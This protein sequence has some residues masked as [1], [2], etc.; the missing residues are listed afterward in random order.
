MMASISFEHG[1]TRAFAPKRNE[2]DSASFPHSIRWRIPASPQSAAIA[3]DVIPR[4][5]STYFKNCSG[6]CPTARG[7]ADLVLIF[8]SARKKSVLDQASVCTPALLQSRF[9]D[10]RQ[11]RHLP[12]RRQLAGSDL[13]VISRIFI[14]A[15]EHSLR[16][17]FPENPRA[18]RAKQSLRMV[19][20]SVCNSSPHV[21]HNNTRTNGCV[22]ILFSKW[23][24]ENV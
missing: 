19:G 20:A 5:S 1:I 13:V 14:R 24:N 9:R 10:G 18:D 7:P 15:R 12:I 4:I 21:G 8:R 6:T 3:G 11:S 2:R 23:A 17:Q 22:Q 16:F